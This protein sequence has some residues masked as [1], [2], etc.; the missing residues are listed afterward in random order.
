MNPAIQKRILAARNLPAEG[1]AAP[2]V[3]PAVVIK[4]G[5][6]G[7]NPIQGTATDSALMAPHQRNIPSV[8]AN[9]VHPVRST[10]LGHGSAMQ[11]TLMRHRRNIGGIDVRVALPPSH[12]VDADITA[13]GTA[14][15][16]LPQHPRTHL[17][18][19]PH[20][21]LIIDATVAVVNTAADAA[22]VTPLI[23][24]AWHP[25]HVPRLYQDTCKTG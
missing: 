23:Q 1:K 20:L 18:Q 17:L 12:H 16:H 3:H 11:V 8:T 2:E 4:A 6:V 19:A 25:S 14:P 22:D 10:A 24:Q 5:P 9:P 13:I 7:Q 21:H 15:C